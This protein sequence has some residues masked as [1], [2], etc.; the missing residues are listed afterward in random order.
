MSRQMLSVLFI[1]VSAIS[2]SY[3][4]SFDAF[5]DNNLKATVQSQGPMIDP[6]AIK[7]AIDLAL[8]KALSLVFQD[9]PISAALLV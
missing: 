1:A 5:F 8:G 3:G 4:Q 7:Y 2:L 9:L 6:G